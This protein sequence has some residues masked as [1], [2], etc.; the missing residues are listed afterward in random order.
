MIEHGIYIGRE[1]RLIGI[2]Y[3]HSRIRPPKE[4]LRYRCRVIQFS[5]NLQDSPSRTEGKTGHPFLMEHTFTLAHPND[6][7][8]IGTTFDRIIDRQECARTMMLRPVELDSTGNP[9]TGQTDQSRFNHMVIID[10]MAVFDF[11][12]CHLYTSAQLRE[13]HNFDIFV[14][15][16]NSMITLF[17]AGIFNLF[18]YRI[19]IHHSTTSLVNT[20]LQEHRILFGFANTVSRKKDIFFPHF[21]IFSHFSIFILLILFPVLPM[22]F[23]L[24]QEVLHV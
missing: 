19:R 24:F 3:G 4:S 23:L 9:R 22:F 14:F 15:K 18:H 5:L 8:A 21:Y 10:E 12:V 6:G 7:T 2:I 1:H 16:I 11:I 17:F 13:D 20:L